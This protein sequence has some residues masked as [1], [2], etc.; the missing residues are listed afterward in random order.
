M[1]RRGPWARPVGI[2]GQLSSMG[3]GASCRCAAAST[4]GTSAGAA[5][6]QLRQRQRQPWGQDAAGTGGIPAS[7]AIAAAAVYSSANACY[8]N[9]IL[10]VRAAFTGNIASASTPRCPGFWSATD[11]H[12]LHDFHWHS[13]PG[14]DRRLFVARPGA[15]GGSG[16]AG[17]VARDVDLDRRF[18]RDF[19]SQIEKSLWHRCAHW[20]LETPAPAATSA[21]TVT[22]TA[23]SE[24]CREYLTRRGRRR[25]TAVCGIAVDW[26]AVPKTASAAAAIPASLDQGPACQWIRSTPQGASSDPWQDWCDSLTYSSACS[27]AG[28]AK[29]TR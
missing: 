3:P 12:K 25:F 11:P 29:A 20:F 13:C 7:A 8:R 1:P 26:A 2:S 18:P 27:W 16:V 22:T 5:E 14:W 17:P 23:G 28:R 24:A 10:S 21:P 9:V 15:S 19:P 4:L 6:R